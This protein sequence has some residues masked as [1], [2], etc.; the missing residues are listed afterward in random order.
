[1]GGFIPC[2]TPLVCHCSIWSVIGQHVCSTLW[3]EWRP[4]SQRWAQ[5]SQQKLTISCPVSPC[6]LCCHQRTQRKKSLLSS[7]NRR[8]VYV[9]AYIFRNCSL[10]SSY[11]AIFSA[12]YRKSSLRNWMPPLC[13]NLTD[14]VNWEL[15]SV[16]QHPLLIIATKAWKIIKTLA[17]STTISCRSDDVTDGPHADKYSDTVSDYES[18]LIT[19][20][21]C[22][23]K[24]VQ[25]LTIFK[26]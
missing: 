19:V 24:M 26:Y 17:T 25:I 12:E 2:L 8:F 21:Q 22:V 10:S 4:V 16:K 11:S 1:M 13:V 14:S 23:S 3:S 6:W 9:C 18:V 20:Q 5:R 15:H 7:K